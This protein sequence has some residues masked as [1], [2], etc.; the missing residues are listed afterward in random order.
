MPDDDLTCAECHKPAPADWPRTAVCECGSRSWDTPLAPA[1][2]FKAVAITHKRPPWFGAFV[3]S[4]EAP[5]D[6]TGS[7]HVDA[8]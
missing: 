5:K 1:A 8:D 2:F 4:P 7:Q 3:P 6:S